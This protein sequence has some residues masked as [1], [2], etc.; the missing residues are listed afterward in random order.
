MGQNHG[1]TVAG[2]NCPKPTAP[3]PVTDAFLGLPREEEGIDAARR[4]RDARTG[5]ALHP[6]Q[7]VSRFDARRGATWGGYSLDID[8]LDV[9]AD[10]ERRRRHRRPGG[11]RK[12]PVILR[13]VGLVFALL[14][15]VA[16]AL[17]T[18]EGLGW[19]GEA[20]ESS[21][22]NQAILGP[23]IAGFGIALAYVIARRRR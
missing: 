4:A 23:A 5:K 18:A 11:S 21:Q 3:G 12:S 7:P 2:S 16:G 10:W 13:L 17:W 19:T 22:R 20:S 9:H 14:M 6:P 15:I 1:T 8:R